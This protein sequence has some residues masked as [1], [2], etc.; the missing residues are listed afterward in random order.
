M[1]VYLILL[2]FGDV[3]PLTGNL[4]CM[5]RK[6][7]MKEKVTRMKQRIL[8]PASEFFFPSSQLPALLPINLPR[9]QWS[10]TEPGRTTGE[11]KQWWTHSSLP[12]PSRHA[13]HAGVCHPVGLPRAP[14]HILSAHKYPGKTSCPTPK[15]DPEI[16]EREMEQK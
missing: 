12:L 14:R 11:D 9:P 10:V 4:K 5:T 13:P 6:E 8:L 3:K 16:N 7:D 15:H 2:C 1:Y